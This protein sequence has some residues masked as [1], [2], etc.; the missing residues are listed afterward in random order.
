MAVEQLGY[1]SESD[2]MTMGRN[3]STPISFYG[4]TP[5][6]RY[7]GAGAAS[8]YTTTTNT[9]AVFGLNSNAAVTS[10]VLQVSTLTVA[11][12]NLGLID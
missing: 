2:G 8:T 11:L 1:N 12:R 6:T 9:T 10:L 3:S 5:I 7:V 4:S